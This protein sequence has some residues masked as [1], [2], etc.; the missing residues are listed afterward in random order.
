MENIEQTPSAPSAPAAPVQPS[1]PPAA[2]NSLAEFRAQKAQSM[3]ALVE[4]TPDQPPSP[5]PKPTE[6]RV[7]TA[8]EDGPEITD[9]GS[10]P[11][12]APET[13]QGPKPPE[14]GPDHRWRDP[15]TGIRLDMRRRDHRQMKRAL[16]DR[17]ALARRLEALEARVTQP[18]APAP[19]PARPQP[20]AFQPD[21]NDPEPTLEQFADAPDPYA[22]HTRAVAKWEARQE[23]KQL[24]ASQARVERQRQA[25]A[26][27]S[28]AQSDYDAGLPQARERYPDF[29]AAHDEVLAELGRL[30]LP[31]RAPLVQ[32]L[33]TS[34]LRHDLTH[35]LGS[36]PDDLAV[37]LAA[38]NLHEQGIA[39]GAIE[40]RV[41]ALVNQ[42]NRPA[43]SHP[44][45]PPPAPMAPVGGN[46]SPAAI[47]DGRNMTLA[48]FRANKSKLGMT[49]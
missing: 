10:E 35:Y 32:R 8:L 38:R 13:P 36:H 14:Q 29:D 41:R 48:Q 7:H 9:E 2:P 1:A 34:P 21:P 26:A 37:V 17:A 45:P 42:R 30:P 16:E 20:Q 31:A 18:P 3:A 33:L 27:L 23:F 24:Q 19:P 11:Q 47:P 39:L 12:A 4:P 15:E 25:A 49:A 40:T 44:T 28:H 5:T 22:A 6:P 43:P 46:A